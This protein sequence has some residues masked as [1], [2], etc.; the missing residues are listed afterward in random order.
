V[1]DVERPDRATG[2]RAVRAVGCLAVAAVAAAGRGDDEA[3]AAGAARFCGRAAA[4]AE[5][6]PDA[7]EAAEAAAAVGSRA[8]L[9]AALGIAA[10]ILLDGRPQAVGAEDR[11]RAAG[12]MLL[13]CIILILLSCIT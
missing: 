12:A 10:D 7:A 8:R 6:D 2:D 3:C 4:A 11:M 13:S 1:P 9:R 5:E